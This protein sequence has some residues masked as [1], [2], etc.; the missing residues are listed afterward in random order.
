MS[1]ELLNNEAQKAELEKIEKVK[2]SLDKIVN[3]KSK[4]LFVIPDS[5]G[6]TASVYEMYFHATV[7]KNMGYEVL[8]MVEKSDYVIPIWIEKELTMFKHVSMADPKLMVGPEDIMVIPDIYSNVMEQTKNLPCQRIGL[9]QS[10]DY[11]INSLIPGTDWKSFN[12]NDIITTSETLKEWVETFQGKGKFNIQVYDVGIPDYFQ[13]SSIP[14]KPVVSVV[15]RNANE[16]SKLVKVFFSRYPQYSWIVFDPMLTKSK[17]PQQMR[18]VDFA[19]RLQGN[20]AAVWIDRISSFGTFPLECMKSGVIPICLKPDITPEYI[21]ER[22]GTGDTTVVKIAE[23]AG[24]WTDNYYDLPVLIGEVLIKFLDDAISPALYTS[25]EKVAEKYT[26]ENS[27]KRLTEIY[28]G[29][30][31]QRITLFSNVL[32]PP[33]PPQVVV[34]PQA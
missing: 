14:Q 23:G 6:P 34:T 24:I 29:F 9:L 2:V 31:D 18:R 8:I 13:R 21:L 11:M 10:V 25:M 15:G 20:F 19:K 22:Q 32:N 7:V 33:Q 12:I 27:E 26:Q 28:Q 5:P 1:E 3:K 4:F 30:I 16:I 17:P